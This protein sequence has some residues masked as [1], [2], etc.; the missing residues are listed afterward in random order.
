MIHKTGKFIKVVSEW[1]NL[2]KISYLHHTKSSQWPCEEES[3]PFSKLAL[4]EPNCFAKVVEPVTCGIAFRAAKA[5][6]GAEQ[7]GSRR[8]EL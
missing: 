3:F 8:R 5:Q 2:G 7:Y 1:L 6:E 4:R